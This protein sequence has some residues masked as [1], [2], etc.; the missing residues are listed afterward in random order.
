VDGRA[1]LAGPVPPVRWT[2]RDDALGDA[3][4]SSHNVAAKRELFEIG[5]YPLALAWLL[6]GR[7]VE[8]VYAAAGTYFFAPHRER[9]AEDFA[10]LMLTLEGGLPVSVSTGRTGRLSHPGHGR[11]A[12]RVVGTEGSMSLDGGRPAV[13]VYGD[14][15]ARDDGGA[16]LL[17]SGVLG[18]TDGFGPAAMVDH[19]VAVLDGKEESMLDAETGC[20]LAVA[21]LAAYE[22][23]AR[24]EAVDIPKE[25]QT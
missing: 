8:R 7:R 14:V 11:M 23:A 19:F 4:E 9:G 6:T 20:H 15:R 13:A 17:G 3:T 25:S 18:V 1:P 21:L 10:T 2:L 16:G 12:L 22:S 24:G 5:W